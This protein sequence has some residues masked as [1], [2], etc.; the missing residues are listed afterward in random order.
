MWLRANF[1]KYLDVEVYIEELVSFKI[2][3]FLEILHAE[4]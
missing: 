2:P 1:F 4:I 3:E